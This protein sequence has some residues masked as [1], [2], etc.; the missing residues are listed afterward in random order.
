MSLYNNVAQSLSRGGL[1]GS[2][3]GS[4]STITNSI[5]QRA[6]SMMGNGELA[7]AIGSIGAATGRNVVINQI[8]K[9]IP[10]TARRG[11]NV[12][13]GVVGD[14]MRGDVNAA[15]LRILDSGLLNKLLPGMSAAASQAMYWNRRSPL[16]GGITP[17][18]ALRIYETMQSTRLAKKNL[19]L[20]E[21][22]SRLM[23][24]WVSPWLNMFATEIEYAPYIVGS[25]KH[26]TGGS[27]IDS[28]RTGDPVE[29]RIS[30]MDDQFGTIKKWYELHHSSAV[31]QDGTVGLPSM[32]AIK[33]NIIH[34]FVTRESTLYGAY[35][36]IGWFRPANL[37]ISLSRREDAMAEVQMTFSQIDTFIKA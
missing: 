29:M 25:D 15:G 12:G 9:H 6:A 10:I 27:T 33:F 37:E 19:F 31:A 7:K 4:A 30:T 22:S 18:E 23:G 35:E 32:Y 20:V 28:V 11:L 2:V 26:R 17:T 36:S 24:D 34:S 13:A 21:A 1:T 3:I 8:N 5:G 14:I 16:F